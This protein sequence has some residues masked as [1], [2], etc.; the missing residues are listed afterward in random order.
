MFFR[1]NPHN[2]SLDHYAFAQREIPIPT[3]DTMKLIKIAME[4]VD[5][6]YQLGYLYKKAGVRL[7]D[8]FDED[9]YQIGL[10]E[11]GDDQKSKVLME[12]IDKINKTEGKT[13][14]KPLACGVSGKAYKMA[15][16]FKSPDYL[17]GWSELPQVK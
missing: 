11:G 12:L 10:F 17:T 13:L 5:E 4:L 9:H 3:A 15:R 8:F 2:A 14:L 6:K 16:S 1:T 7:G